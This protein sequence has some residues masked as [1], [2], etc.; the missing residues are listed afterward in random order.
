MVSILMVKATMFKFIKKFIKAVF[1]AAILS[2]LVKKFQR[3]RHIKK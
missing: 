1:I 2:A 3:Y